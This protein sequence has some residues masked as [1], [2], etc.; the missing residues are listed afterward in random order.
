[1]FYGGG[2]LVEDFILIQFTDGSKP[3]SFYAVK[4]LLIS[5]IPTYFTDGLARGV[6]GP[7]RGWAMVCASYFVVMGF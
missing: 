5:C 4:R 3:G 2:Q 1:M 6:K 7:T